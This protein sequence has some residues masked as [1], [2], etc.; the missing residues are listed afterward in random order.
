MSIILVNLLLLVWI[1]FDFNS[2]F[3]LFHSLFFI[4]GSWIFKSSDNIVRLYPYGFFYDIGKKIFTG[5]FVYGIILI[6]VGFFSID[7]IKFIAKY[8]K[9]KI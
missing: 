1:L 8:L 2:L 7:K 4:E 5:I 6:I 3:N 9:N